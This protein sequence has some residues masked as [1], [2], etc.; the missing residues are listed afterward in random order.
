MDGKKSFSNFIVEGAGR[1]FHCWDLRFK[2]Y[3]LCSKGITFKILWMVT[4]IRFY[5]YLRFRVNLYRLLICHADPLR[6]LGNNGLLDNINFSVLC[7]ILFGIVYHW[8][9][10][11]TP[12]GFVHRWRFYHPCGFHLV[13]QRCPHHFSFL[14]YFE[15]ICSWKAENNSKKRQ[16]KEKC[17]FRP[18]FWVRSTQTL[19]QIYNRQNN[20][21]KYHLNSTDKLN[22]YQ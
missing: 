6:S 1:I 15:L 10:M 11:Q 8:R 20:I 3:L 12:Q 7:M 5:Q 9:K 13:F 14:N 22:K 17:L 18:A 16:K 2:K 19:V 4:H 21:E